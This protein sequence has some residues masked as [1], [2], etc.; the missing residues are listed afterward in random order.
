M[1]GILTYISI[2][3]LVGMWMLGWLG[4]TLLLGAFFDLSAKGTAITGAILGPLGFVAILFVGIA[5]SKPHKKAQ[6]SVERMTTSLRRPE[7]PV[8]ISDPFA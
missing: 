3:M 7:K 5:T 2:L 4:I 8:A 1:K 6:A